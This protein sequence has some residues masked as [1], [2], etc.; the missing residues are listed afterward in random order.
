MVLIGIGGGGRK[1]SRK[2][3]TYNT[4][5]CVSKSQRSLKCKLTNGMSSCNN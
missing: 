3:T 4:D 5:V 2:K 1:E